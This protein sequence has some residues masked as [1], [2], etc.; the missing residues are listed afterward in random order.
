MNVSIIYSKFNQMTHALQVNKFSVNKVSDIYLC[1]LSI[2]VVHLLR[3]TIFIIHSVHVTNMCLVT[4]RKIVNI[5]DLARN[6]TM[7]LCNSRYFVFRSA[8]NLEF[9]CCDY[10]ETVTC[11]LYTQR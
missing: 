3:A 7:W 9:V 11:F 6:V 4:F 1:S 2:D 8:D 10:A 5:F